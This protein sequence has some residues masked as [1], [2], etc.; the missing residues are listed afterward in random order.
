MTDRFGLT[1]PASIS[2]VQCP[3]K[4]QKNRLMS[5]VFERHSSLTITQGDSLSLT[6]EIGVSLRACCPNAT[7]EGRAPRGPKIIVFLS[8]IWASQ[9]WASEFLRVVDLSKTPLR[10]PLQTLPNSKSQIAN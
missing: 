3:L 9:S 1:A 4:K 7:S 5:S 10:R 6:N 8:E 2:S